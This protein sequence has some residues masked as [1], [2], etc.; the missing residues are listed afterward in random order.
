MRMQLAML[1][2]KARYNARRRL[3]SLRRYFCHHGRLRPID[4]RLD[5]S[6]ERVIQTV[7][8]TRCGKTWFFHFTRARA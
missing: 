6:G 8:C 3:E 1:W 5:R 4:V 2:S 7:E